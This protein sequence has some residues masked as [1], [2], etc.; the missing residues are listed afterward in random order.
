MFAKKTGPEIPLKVKRTWS[1]SRVYTATLPVPLNGACVVCSRKAAVVFKSKGATNL[2]RANNCSAI[3]KVCR[4][5]EASLLGRIFRL[6]RAALDGDKVAR[7]RE[8]LFFRWQV[9]SFPILSGT[10]RYVII[11][12]RVCLWLRPHLEY[13]APWN[14]AEGI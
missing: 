5:T 2:I 12:Q 7:F 3:T 11:Q 14:V 6:S 9:R 10:Q 4:Y 1:S 13:F 8:V